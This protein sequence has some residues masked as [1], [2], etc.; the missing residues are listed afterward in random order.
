M[1]FADVE[2]GRLARWFPKP[3]VAG[4]SHVVRFGSSWRFPPP[5]RDYAAPTSR[6]PARPSTPHHARSGASTCPPLLLLLDALEAGP[7]RAPR[8][9]QGRSAPRPMNPARELARHASF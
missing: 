3:G 7:M 2:L 4:S 8:R 9:T 5:V 6:P 1:R